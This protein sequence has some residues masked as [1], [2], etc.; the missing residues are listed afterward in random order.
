MWKTFTKNNFPI[1]SAYFFLIFCLG[2]VTLKLEEKF[3]L[4]FYVQTKT[5]FWNYRERERERDQEAGNRKKIVKGSLFSGFLQWN[6]KWNWNKGFQ[7]RKRDI[8][9]KWIT[10]SSCMNKKIL[11]KTE[12]TSDFLKEYSLEPEEFDCNLFVYLCILYF[13]LFF[14]SL[15]CFLWLSSQGFF[16]K[17][18]FSFFLLL[19]F[20]ILFSFL[21]VKRA[22]ERERIGPWDCISFV[23]CRCCHVVT[24]SALLFGLLCAS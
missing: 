8:T 16:S 14:S 9:L 1:F 4:K 11:N 17:T 7:K 10:L 24:P 19:F 12:L 6:H 20:V 5:T 15:F 22:G 21:T 23:S 3:F 13:F 2:L 18:I